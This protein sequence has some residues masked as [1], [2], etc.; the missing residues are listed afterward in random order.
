MLKE[1][2]R[3]A[4]SKALGGADVRLLSPRDKSFG[5]F[6]VNTHQLDG[7]NLPSNE[8]LAQLQNLDECEQVALVGNFINFFVKKEILAEELVPKKT[9]VD[10]SKTWL[11]EHTS[12]NPNKAMHLGHLR[13]NVTGMAIANIWEYTGVRV[14]RDAIDND[15][16]IAIARLMWGYLKYAKKSEDVSGDIAYWYAHKDEWMTPKEAVESPGK[17]VDRR[18]MTFF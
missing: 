5:D 8:I 6:A 11:L 13:N 4:V 15:R 9:A 14:I 1:K 7:L 17:F 3:N 18:Y 16:G 2:I 12:P 10:K